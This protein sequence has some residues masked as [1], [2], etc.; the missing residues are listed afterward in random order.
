VPDF[1]PRTRGTIPRADRTESPAVAEH[2]APVGP[3]GRPCLDGHLGHTADRGHRLAA[4]PE[5]ADPEQVVGVLQLAGG[6]AGEH[7]RQV[8]RVDPVPVVHDADQ[9]APA[10][11]EVDVDSGSSGIDRVLKQLLDDGR[12]PLDHLAG[13]D[14]GDYGRG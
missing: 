2:L 3:A 11:F 9:L 5:G 4:E 6:V 1:Y 14:L 13:G 7:E 8:G 12:R 10:L